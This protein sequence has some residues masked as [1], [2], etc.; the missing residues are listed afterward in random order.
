M[1]SFILENIFNFIFSFYAIPEPDMEDM[2]FTLQEL[3]KI[4]IGEPFSVVV[5]IKNKS[6]E[7]RTINAVLSAGSVFYTGI[8]ANQVKKAQG[9]FKVKPGA[10]KYIFW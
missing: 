6:E 8:K 4:N 9:E 5:S 1:I 2:E 10:S 3:E 7:V